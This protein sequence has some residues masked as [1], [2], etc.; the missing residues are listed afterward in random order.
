MLTQLDF[1]LVTMDEAC[2]LFPVYVKI[3]ATL[4]T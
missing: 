4:W 1:G 3:F 2:Y